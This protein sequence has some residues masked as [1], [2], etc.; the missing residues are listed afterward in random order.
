MCI[1]GNEP[2]KKQNFRLWEIGIPEQF[3]ISDFGK[4][5]SSFP[6]IVVGLPPPASGP[7]LKGRKLN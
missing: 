7:K 2:R 3:L 1:A 5:V 4:R 6:G